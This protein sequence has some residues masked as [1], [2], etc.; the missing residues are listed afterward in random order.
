ML[1]DMIEMESEIKQQE[2]IAAKLSVTNFIH[3][4][5]TPVGYGGWRMADDS[6]SECHTPP[7]KRIGPLKDIS[8][9]HTRM[10]HVY[11]VGF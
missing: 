6:R 10:P 5:G 11:F 2:E 7:M 3:V 9:Y 8:P 4:A 1:L